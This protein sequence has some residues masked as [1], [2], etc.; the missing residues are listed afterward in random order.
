MWRNFKKLILSITNTNIDVK[1]TSATISES[2]INLSTF[3]R[4]YIVSLFYA[5][6]KKET[7][8]F[9]QRSSKFDSRIVF[10]TANVAFLNI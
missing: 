5:I 1:N 2:K 6:E 3:N 8:I 7:T 9:G 4:R 10:S